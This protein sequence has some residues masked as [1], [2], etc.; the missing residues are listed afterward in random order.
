MQLS[1]T[2]SCFCDS[3]LGTGCCWFLFVYVLLTMFR[4]SRMS[5]LRYCAVTCLKL[6]SL[7]RRL[8][9]H[10]RPV[11]LTAFLAGYT[12][13]VTLWFPCTSFFCDNLGCSFLGS[14][15]SD[16]I[17]LHWG[18]RLAFLG[19]PHVRPVNQAI[20]T[21]PVRVP[22]RSKKVRGTSCSSICFRIVNT[23]PTMIRSTCLLTL[24]TLQLSHLQTER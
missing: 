1:G 15:A 9:L 10:V 11:G 8:H 5:R 17:V 2:P 24:E 18:D 7:I 4:V 16:S 14:S 22:W 21:S 19:G 23:Y 20:W 6:T 3:F 12:R 13:G